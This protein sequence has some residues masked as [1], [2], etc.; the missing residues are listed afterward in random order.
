MTPEER[1][2]LASKFTSISE[3]L[4]RR[5]YVADPDSGFVLGTKIVPLAK[6]QM[7]VSAFVDWA[8]GQGMLGHPEKTEGVGSDPFMDAV[9]DHILTQI[10]EQ[11]GIKKELLATYKSRW[12]EASF[13]LDLPDGSTITSGPLTTSLTDTVN[14]KVKHY[15]PGRTK[16]DDLADAI[17]YVTPA[18]KHG[19]DYDYP[20]RSI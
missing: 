16:L 19:H 2:T 6:L 17:R 8:D 18:M 14:I 3:L 4:E 20:Q 13:I 7:S 5:G 10:S 11:L 15:Y 1:K 9:M 12:N